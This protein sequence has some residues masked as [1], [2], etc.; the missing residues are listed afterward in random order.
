MSLSILKSNEAVGAANSYVANLTDNTVMAIKNFDGATAMI[1]APGGFTPAQVITYR[2]QAAR[3]L[4]RRFAEIKRLRRT[5]EEVLDERTG[6]VTR[7]LTRRITGAQH[8]LE[9]F[10]KR[11]L[12][13]PCDAFAWA[14]S[15]MSAA[16]IQKVSQDLL[17]SVVKYGL[18]AV[19][20]DATRKL[21][22]EA[23]WPPSSTSQ[24]SNQ[25]AQLKLAALAEFVQ[26]EGELQ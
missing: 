17:V 20:K 9:R 13:D 1:V 7:W 11:L 23:R 19:V 15:A 25:M 14:D 24:A 5:P 12:D 8:D 4:M 22:N 26:A 10:A 2:E 18:L 6:D 16:A 3:Q 21:L